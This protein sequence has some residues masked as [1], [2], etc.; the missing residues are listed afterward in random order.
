MFASPTLVSIGVQT[1]VS[2]PAE[3]RPQLTCC[4]CRS[5]RFSQEFSSQ[6]GIN[7]LY[8]RE[9]SGVDET[10]EHPSD[11][12]LH[13][14]CDTIESL[15]QRKTLK[16][17]SSTYSSDNGRPSDEIIDKLLLNSSLAAID[18]RNTRFIPADTSQTGG[19]GDN[20]ELYSSSN[21]YH[22][23]NLSQASFENVK[24]GVVENGN[25]VSFEN[26]NGE[27]TEELEDRQYSTT[28][29][30]QSYN[31]LNETDQL[32]FDSELEY[33]YEVGARLSH[34]SVFCFVFVFC[35]I[36]F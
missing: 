27:R 9:D 30:L 5:N 32:Y 18:K 20:S 14:G 24:Q 26:S 35:Y 7:S 3:T 19:E 16:D 17:Y 12:E 33:E 4:R 11:V 34:L 36:L 15:E 6:G 28:D 21:G 25:V 31:N 23:G 29:D 8:Q 1:E 2:G 22:S 13:N 10:G